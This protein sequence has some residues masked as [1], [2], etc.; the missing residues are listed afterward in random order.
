MNSKYWRQ[1]N[2]LP[3]N[4]KGAYRILEW[5]G[6]KMPEYERQ[7]IKLF[8]WYYISIVINVIYSFTTGYDVCMAPITSIRTF[9]LLFL[10]TGIIVIVHENKRVEG[11]AKERKMSANQNNRKKILSK[12]NKKPIQHFNDAIYIRF[13]YAEGGTMLLAVIGLWLEKGAMF[14]IFLLLL[15]LINLF[16]LYIDN[17]VVFYKAS[18][19]K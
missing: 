8:F 15:A 13:M 9:L 6:Y 16:M 2:A 1:N 10:S 4:V 11:K 19:F 5:A 7:N 12:K 14:R 17:A 18:D 3:C